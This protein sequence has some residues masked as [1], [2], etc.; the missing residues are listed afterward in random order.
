MTRKLLVLVIPL[1][2]L[3]SVSIAYAQNIAVTTAPTTANTGITN[4]VQTATAGSMPTVTGSTATV[5]D[6]ALKL[7][8][9]MQL[10]QDQKQAEIAKIANDAKAAI[11]AKRAEFT[12]KLQTIKDQNK[13]A[14]V[15]R[16]DTRLTQINTNQTEKYTQVIGQLQTFLDKMSITASGTA[17]MTEITTAQ[18]AI[19]TAKAAV[20]AQAEKAYTMA[21]TDDTA[22]KLNAGTIVDQFRQDINSVYGLVLNAKQTIHNLI[23]VKPVLLIKPA[24][25]SANL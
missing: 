7:K 6:P 18:N 12:A 9:Q 17:K 14:I 25:N 5:M 15:E 16:I 10:V 20:S 13:K 21:I 8:Q 19:D 4:S 24:S 11:Q 23:P 1:L 3:A 22:L 2:L